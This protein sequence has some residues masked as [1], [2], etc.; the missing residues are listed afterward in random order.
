MFC[1]KNYDYDWI[2]RVENN[3]DQYRGQQRHRYHWKKKGNGTFVSSKF[4][5]NDP[6]DKATYLPQ[7]KM[8]VGQACSALIRS[9]AAVRLSNRDGETTNDIKHRILMLQG[10]LKIEKDQSLIEDLLPYGYSEEELN[11]LGEEEKE[12]DSW[13]LY[14]DDEEESEPEQEEIDPELGAAEQAQLRREEAESEDDGW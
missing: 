13:T 8:T 4:N 12:K 1:V 14:D 10:A 5:F 11:Q 7:V 9:W 3:K 6:Y 2:K